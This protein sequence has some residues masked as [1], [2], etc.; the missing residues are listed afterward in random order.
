MG[1][2]PLLLNSIVNNNMHVIGCGIIHEMCLLN[3]V[4]VGL[5]SI[6]SYRYTGQLLAPSFKGLRVADLTLDWLPDHFKEVNL[7]HSITSLFL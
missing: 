7:D 5:L 6:V 1:K 3:A 4:D 2:H